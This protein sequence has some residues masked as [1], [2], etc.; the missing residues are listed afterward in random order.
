MADVKN[1]WK[2][3]D[4][5]TSAAMNA[6]GDS[7]NANT[8]TNIAQD[9]VIEQNKKDIAANAEADAITVSN[10]AAAMAAIEALS[11]KFA[12]LSA[13]VTDLAHPAAVAVE[14]ANGYNDATVDAMVA[15]A[16][17]SDK[18][19]LTAKSFVMIRRI[20]APQSRVISSARCHTN[21]VPK[22]WMLIVESVST[23]SGWGSLSSR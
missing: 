2:A 9:K 19:A 5:V 4:V 13:R 1:D 6:V 15:D 10:V 11:S 14:V 16:T 20:S 12:T 21:R 3:G 8:A 23:T 7:V 17:V 18:T 22:L